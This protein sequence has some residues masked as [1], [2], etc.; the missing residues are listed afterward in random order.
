MAG[1]WNLVG[2]RT[3]MAEHV[4]ITLLRVELTGVA[5]TVRTRAEA[6][7][8]IENRLG[9]ALSVD[10]TTDLT[11]IADNLEIGTTT[12]RLVYAAKLEMILNAGE[13]GLSNETEFRSIL[14]IS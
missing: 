5:L 7:A 6:K 1:L 3:E 2:D 14:G 9:R 13:L 4:N 8:N 10:E 12:D 11:A